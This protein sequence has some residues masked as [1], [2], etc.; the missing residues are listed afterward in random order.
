MSPASKSVTAIARATLALALALAL[1]ASATAQS[2]GRSYPVSDFKIEFT[3]GAPD[4]IDADALLDL[5]VGLRADGD[6][7]VAPRPVDRTVRMRLSSLPRNARFSVSAIQHINQ[8]IIST[9]NRRGYYGVIVTVPE[10]EE[11]TG[12]DL[13]PPGHT[14]LLLRIWTSRVTRL[15]TMADGERFKG[16]TTDERTDNAAHEWIRERAPVQPGGPKDRVDVQ[17]LED[18]AAKLSRHPGRRVDVELEAGDRPG[19]TAVNLRVAESKPWYAY[20]QYANTGTDATT[21]NRERLGLV[22]DQLFGRDD[23]LRIDYVTGDFD[24]VHSVFASYEAPFSLRAPDWRFE[25]DGWYSKFDASEVGFSGGRFV[26]EQLSGD[27]RLHVNVFQRHELFV[28]LVAG[29]R[30]QQMYVDNFL[31]DES[32]RVSFLMPQLGL[33]GD[34][35]TRTSTLLFSAGA[36]AGF[37]DANE[38]ELA[39]LGRANPSR[40]FALL[41]FDASFSFYLEPLIDPAA[42]QDPSTPRSSTLA[43]EIAVLARGQWAFDNRLVPQYQQIAGGMY[44]V[45]GYPQA[46]SV[47]DNLLLGSAEYRF[48]LPRIFRPDATPPEVPGMGQFRARPQHVWGRPDW[49]LILRIF[50]DAARVTQNGESGLANE[51]NDTLWSAGAGVEL[52]LLRNLTVRVDT[53]VALEDVGSTNRGDTE[54]HVVATL[55]Y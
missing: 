30:F 14:S 18:Y 20:A 9:L 50:T 42:W 17:A 40:D 44:T 22:H 28:D 53:G 43:H 23:I 37:T 41:H 7:Y 39:I 12:R 27:A 52:Q 8:Y 3:L 4:H 26:G 31:L 29:G 11:G 6:V 5:E 10:I 36:D 33:A 25:L 54:T 19:T 2:H 1:G 24:S 51:T 47:G 32:T 55:L 45:R 13:R 34:R 35:T 46:I 16:L 38:T 49:D 15:T 21:K 48:H